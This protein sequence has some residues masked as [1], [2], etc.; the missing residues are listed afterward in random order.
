VPIRFT[1][2]ILIVSIGCGNAVAPPVAKPSVPAT[3][4]SSAIV[5]P[6][7]TDLGPLPP[8]GQ[9]PPRGVATSRALLVKPVADIEKCTA[10]A[11]ATDSE[12]LGGACAAATKTRRVL[13]PFRINL[14]ESS[15]HEEQKVRVEKGRCYRVYVG[16]SADLSALSITARDAQGILVLDENGAAVPHAGLMCA[17]ESGEVTLLI[18][19]GQGR[20]KASLSVWSD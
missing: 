13:G 7:P 19:A 2:V 12:K 16:R 11:D 4:A 9:A 1:R 5:A 18:A 20:G 10:N 17:S 8:A 3:V 15:K 6:V 14:D